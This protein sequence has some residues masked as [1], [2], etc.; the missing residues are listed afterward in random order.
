MNRQTTQH[1]KTWLTTVSRDQ[2][3]QVEHGIRVLVAQYPDLLLTHSW[4][5]MWALAERN[6]PL[7]TTHSID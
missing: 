2:R 3:R 7:Y 6:F 4:P 1:L 5:E